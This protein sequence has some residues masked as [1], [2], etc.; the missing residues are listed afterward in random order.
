MV[1]IDAV[2]KQILP[3]VNSTHFGT[4]CHAYLHSFEY[5]LSYIISDFKKNYWINFK[6]TMT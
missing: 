2:V 5:N 4:L 6:S 3:N 1:N